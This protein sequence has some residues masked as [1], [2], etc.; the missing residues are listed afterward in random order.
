MAHEWF[1]DKH[2]GLGQPERLE[3]VIS[4]YTPHLAMIF[5]HPSQDFAR[6]LRATPKMPCRSKVR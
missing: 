3:K 4:V 6:I 2:D 1:P 5:G